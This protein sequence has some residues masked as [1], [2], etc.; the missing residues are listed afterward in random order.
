[1]SP[2]NFN[3]KSLAEHLENLIASQTVLD[4]CKTYA[5]RIDP[6]QSLNDTCMIIEKFFR[7]QLSEESLCIRH[8][9]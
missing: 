1:L 5:E 6:D 7:D 2:K 9:P 4:R 3:A 8:K